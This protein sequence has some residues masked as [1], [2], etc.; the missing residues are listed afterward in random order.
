VR[1]Q[2]ARENHRLSKEREADA[3]LHREQR[4]WLV[5]QLRA[6]DP[7]YWTLARLAKEVGCSR[8][9]IALIVRQPAP[10]AVLGSVAPGDADPTGGALDAPG[11]GDEGGPDAMLAP[12]VKGQSRYLS[13]PILSA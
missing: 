12:A 13:R 3:V 10:P 9:L 1:A 5:R 7:S 4:D 11:D 8:E 6:E 2:Q